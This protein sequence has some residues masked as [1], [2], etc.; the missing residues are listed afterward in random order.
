M[1]QL[2]PSWCLLSS[3]TCLRMEFPRRSN[4]LPF[5]RPVHQLQNYALDYGIPHFQP[6]PFMSSYFNPFPAVYNTFQPYSEISSHCTVISKLLQST[7]ISFKPLQVISR[8]ISQVHK[9]H[10]FKLSNSLI[11]SQGS[12]SPTPSPP[13]EVTAWLH[14][15]MGVAQELRQQKSIKVER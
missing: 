3:H 6:F 15:G 2:A 13:W 10:Y 9:I 1:H 5:L 7:T 4:S 8:K 11:I 14:P 12:V